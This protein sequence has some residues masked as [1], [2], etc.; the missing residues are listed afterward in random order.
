VT[1]VTQVQTWSET[2]GGTRGRASIFDAEDDIDVSGFKPKVTASST[3]APEQV[4]AVSEAASFR[5]REPP[6][7]V[8]REPRRYRTG[9]NVQLNIKARAETIEAFYAVADRQRW[10]LGEAFE[11]AVEALCRE[12]AQQK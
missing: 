8:R 10:V 4:R 7:M 11:R 6:E 5:S 9:R 12:L 1:R 2:C 3:I